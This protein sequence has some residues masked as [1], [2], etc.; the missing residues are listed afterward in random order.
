[1]HSLYLS[2]VVGNIPF[3][4]TPA[5]LAHAGRSEG[6]RERQ[7]D[8]SFDISSENVFACSVLLSAGVYLRLK[9]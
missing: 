1:M 8:A 7:T 3:I 4:F 2:S 6:L 5:I 9:M